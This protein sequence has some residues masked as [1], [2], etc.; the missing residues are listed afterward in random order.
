MSARREVNAGDGDSVT[1]LPVPVC[2]LG[3]ADVIV[4]STLL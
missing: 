1:L 4:S 2:T 3:D